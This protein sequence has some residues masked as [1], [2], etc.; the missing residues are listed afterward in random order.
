M[1]G[2]PGRTKL[3]DERLYLSFQ[4]YMEWK[5]RRNRGDLKPRMGTGL[6]ASAWSHW[7]EA[8][9]SE[10]VASLAGGEGEQA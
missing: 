1:A 5:G 7:V 6:V 9:G 10:G 2:F 4:D 3:V 8:Q